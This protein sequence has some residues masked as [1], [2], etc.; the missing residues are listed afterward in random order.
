[1]TVSR[2]FGGYC[3][4]H[5]HLTMMITMSK[6]EQRV[7]T[8]A[9]CDSPPPLGVGA[10]IRSL[11]PHVLPTMLHVTTVRHLTIMLVANRICR[12]NSNVCNALARF[13]LPIARPVHSQHID[14]SLRMAA[15][16]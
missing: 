3:D 14:P 5:N 9:S 2:Q 13:T 1:M 4:L 11:L 16:M 12:R 10:T 15:T 6:H 7:L 8:A